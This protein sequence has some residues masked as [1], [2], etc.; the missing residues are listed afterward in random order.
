MNRRIVS[1]FVFAVIGMFFSTMLAAATHKL[2]SEKDLVPDKP[3]L[4]STPSFDQG[5]LSLKATLG[6]KSDETL[7]SIRDYR[8]KDGRTITR[9]QQQYQEIPI[10]GHQVIAVQSADGSYVDLR[11]TLVSGIGDDLAA[12]PEKLS[13]KPPKALSIA[14]AH[15]ERNRPTAKRFYRNEKTR[16]VIYP[17]ESGQ[18]QLCYEV[19]FF[20]DGRDTAD[21]AQ[22]LY[23]ID[24]ET[25]TVWLAL[26]QLK[27]ATEVKGGGPGGNAKIGELTYEQNSSETFTVNY[28]QW[29]NRCTMD[30][31]IVETIDLNNGTQGTDPYYYTCDTDDT[32]NDAPANVNG[33]YCP[34]N[35]AQY[36]GEVVYNMYQTHLRESPLG[37][38]KIKLRVHYGVNYTGAFWDGTYATFGD[39]DGVY[40]PRGTLHTIAHELSHGFTDRH[41]GE[42]GTGQKGVINESFSDMGA[43]AA[44]YF[45]NGETPNMYL[46]GYADVKAPGQA[47]RDMCNPTSDGISIDS[48]KDYSDGMS[49]HAAAGVY[50]KAFCLLANSPGWDPEMAFKAFAKANQSYWH[51]NTDFTTGAQD[52]YDAAEYLGY[53][54]GAV[55]DAF[56]AVDILVIGD[57]TYAFFDFDASFLT[58][59]FNDLSVS[60]NSQIISWEWNFGDNSPT[61]NLKNPQHIYEASGTYDVELTVE[62]QI[63]YQTTWWERVTVFE[64][65]CDSLSNT[66]ASEWI[67][68]VGIDTTSYS[69]GA[70]NYSDYTELPNQ[71]IFYLEP[72]QSYPISLTN[73]YSGSVYTE[74]WGVYIDYNN[75]G[76]F[77]D[78]GEEVF[79][80]SGQYNVNGNF[81]VPVWAG[82]EDTRM[83]VVMS[84]GS[85]L[86]PCGKFSWGETEDYMISYDPPPTPQ[87]TADFTYTTDGL[88]A[89]FNNTSTVPSGTSVNWLWT[90]G[91]DST[92]DQENPS[93]SYSSADTYTVTLRVE[94]AD[95]S[96]N[97]DEKTVDV[98]VAEQVGYCESY[99][100]IPSPDREL[101]NTY[102]FGIEVSDQSPQQIFSN[103]SG[104]TNYTDF[105]DKTI[106]LQE[107]Q[108]YTVDLYVD[109]LQ[110]AYED[111]WGLWIDFDNDGD[112]T[113]AGDKVLERCAVGDIQEQI[114]IPNNVSG[115]KR[116]RLSLMGV[117]S[118]QGPCDTT[119]GVGE[120]ED[121]TVEISP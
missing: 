34:V 19:S 13:L 57:D 113:T 32:T 63:G 45:I 21:P 107:N 27:H 41:S 26:D 89:T 40:H 42:I 97:F 30:T 91:D 115:S 104:N 101:Y 118:P 90:F 6:L 82:G 83:R 121:Y 84:G 93:H 50:N 102:I 43:V 106:S 80:G 109:N 111:C 35:D 70:S 110:G 9:Y 22:P 17:N 58:V 72:G 18:A 116:A 8:M 51:Q 23:L 5:I 33:A 95:D 117:S 15:H 1:I 68:E 53:D 88:T 98:T 81:T 25:G 73:D 71:R 16:L 94:D 66:C 86:L 96:A 103:I 108:T 44:D 99:S 65:Y 120:V 24:A 37:S 54:A 87:I 47:R 46:Y 3:F 69:S 48:A 105:T 10:W 77:T 112:F 74:K 28:T 100:I 4:R 49:P 79:T 36:F 39:G 62:D 64:T 7:T 20:S 92:S 75:N 119:H 56:H 85:T 76:L 2:L 60:P 55:K 67:S 14:K 31:S 12:V 61:S 38:N 78:E 29:N 52:V 11:G 114:T 59:N